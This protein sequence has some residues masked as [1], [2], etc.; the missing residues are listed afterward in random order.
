VHQVGFIDKDILLYNMAVVYVLKHNRLF[1]YLSGDR[2]RNF[3]SLI[4]TIFTLMMR[5]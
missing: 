4:H 2:N 5:L 3:Y 1:P